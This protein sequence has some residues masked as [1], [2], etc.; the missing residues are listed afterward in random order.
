MLTLTEYVAHLALPD[1]EFAHAALEKMQ[2]VTDRAWVT[3]TVEAAVWLSWVVE[4]DTDAEGIYALQEVR[5]RVEMLRGRSLF[6]GTP[7]IITK[8]QFT[9][10]HSEEVYCT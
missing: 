4:A 1:G 9:I 3:D 8:G 5:L 10:I 6:Q 2:E 7:L